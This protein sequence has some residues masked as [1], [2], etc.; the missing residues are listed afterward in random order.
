MDLDKLPIDVIQHLKKLHA[1][2]ILVDEYYYQFPPDAIFYI[3]NGLDLIYLFLPLFII[4]KDKI[5][6]LYMHGNNYQNSTILNFDPDPT[7]YCNSDLCDFL[8]KH[9]NDFVRF[10]SSINETNIKDIITKPTISE[11]FK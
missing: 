10:N 11:L 3:T 7:T 8:Y 5:K 2:P 4:K 6:Y 1:N 9:R